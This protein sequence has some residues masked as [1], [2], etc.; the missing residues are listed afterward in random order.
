MKRS[1][2]AAEAIASKDGLGYRIFVVRLSLAMDIILTYVIWITF[3]TSLIDW[4]LSVASRRFYPWAEQT[5]CAFARYP[6]CSRP[7]INARS[8]RG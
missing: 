5:W 3:L 7:T 1:L 4:L 2:I 6:I 8:W